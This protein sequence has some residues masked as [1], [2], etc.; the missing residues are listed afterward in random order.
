[1]H[2]T[3]AYLGAALVLLLT[4]VC[5]KRSSN[6]VEQEVVYLSARARMIRQRRPMRGFIR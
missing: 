2:D 1:M 4:T 3:L 5:S 6:D